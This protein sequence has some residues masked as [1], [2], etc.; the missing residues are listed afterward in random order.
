MY[1]RHII[2]VEACLLVICKHGSS[3]CNLTIISHMVDLASQLQQ[4][5]AVAFEHHMPHSTTERAV[6]DALQHATPA[7]SSERLRFY[8]LRFRV[9][10]VVNKYYLKHKLQ[11]RNLLS[12]SSYSIRPWDFAHPATYIPRTARSIHIFSTEK[13]SP[14]QQRVSP[15]HQEASPAQQHISHGMAP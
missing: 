14:T 8:G 10:T 15:S 13:G 6:E 9:Q 7:V 11:K 4:Q 2:I 3:A 12:S 5:P 1:T